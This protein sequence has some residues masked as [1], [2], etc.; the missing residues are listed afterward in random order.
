MKPTA[1]IINAARGPVIDEAALVETLSSRR[2]RG[3]VLDVFAEQPLS[4]DHP[5]LQLDN[6][7]LTPHAAGI[8]DESMKN[9]SRG[10][11]EEAV[12]LLRFE[13]PENLCN[14]AVWERHLARF[15]SRQGSAT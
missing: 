6:V 12:R 1:A 10:A 9:M 14:P 4:R 11:A 5:F 15:P 2:I 8:T 7:V 3:A 13:R